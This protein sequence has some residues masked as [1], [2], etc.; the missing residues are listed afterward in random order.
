MMTLKSNSN[1]GQTSSEGHT[2]DLPDSEPVDVGS[3]EEVQPEDEEMAAEERRISVS[4]TEVELYELS[5]YFNSEDA[6]MRSEIYE[7]LARKLLIAAAKAGLH[8]EEL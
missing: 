4:F 7:P 8:D 2:H 6:Y 1:T 5:E 3:A